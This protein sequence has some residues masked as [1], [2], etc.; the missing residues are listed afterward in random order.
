MPQH[1]N[2]AKLDKKNSAQE[3][4]WK[5]IKAFLKKMKTFSAKHKGEIKFALAQTKKNGHPLLE[6]SRRHTFTRLY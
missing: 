5:K 2:N 4:F 1:S 3:S 6:D